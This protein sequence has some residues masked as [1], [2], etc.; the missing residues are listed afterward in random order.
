M[1]RLFRAALAC[2]LVL[3]T[4]APAAAQVRRPTQR[5]IATPYKVAVLLIRCAQTFYGP[6]I[7]VIVPHETPDLP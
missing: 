6:R 1:P 7:L 4:T 2:S 3:L 5:V